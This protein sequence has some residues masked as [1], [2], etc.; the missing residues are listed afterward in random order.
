VVVLSHRL[1]QRRFG[2]DAAAVG[3]TLVL[4]TEPHRIVGVLRADFEPEVF[5]QTPDVWVPFQIDPDTRDTGGEFCAVTG[6]LKPGVT[7]ETA[8]AQLQTVASDYHRAFP[9]R[10]QLRGTF[11]LVPI[12]D[13]IVDRSVR[14]TLLLLACAVGLVLII[15]SANVANLLLARGANRSRELSIRASLGASRGRVVRQLLTESLVL[16]IAGAA[17]GLPCGSLGIRALL[18]AY[19]QKN[20]QNHGGNTV[21]IPG[22]AADG[23]A[24]A[25]EWRV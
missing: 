19:P 4:G 5:D 21:S 17:L 3:Q 12:R 15:A 22:N 16:S 10:V 14:S 11:T 7:L 25:T 20:P 6:R 23:S 8:R 9:N 13:A 1:W 24:V 2:G 18:A